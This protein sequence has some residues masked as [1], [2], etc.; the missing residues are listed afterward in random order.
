MNAAVAR[1][2][3]KLKHVQVLD[4]ELHDLRSAV[5]RIPEQLREGEAAFAAKRT[6][7]AAAQENMKGVQL[8]LKEKEIDLGA[9]EERV[10]K[11]DAQLSQVKT[12]QE[13][14]ALQTEIASLK[15]DASLVEDEILK[16]MEEVEAAK[17]AVQKEKERL[18]AEEQVLAREKQVL[19]DERAEKGKRIAE[20]EGQRKAALAEVDREAAQAYDRIVASRAGQAL[21][22]IDGE[23]CG[24]CQ[25]LLRPQ[26]VNEVQLGERLTVC[27]SCSR[28]LYIESP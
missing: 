15:G 13:Y 21:A 25:M 27:E 4:K 2:L 10:K 26:L 1:E 22:R 11:H 24:A 18:A 7:H 14:K 9:K 6:A 12:N 28:I 3:E 5:K 19:A 8:K 23:T 17:A 16:L 20:L